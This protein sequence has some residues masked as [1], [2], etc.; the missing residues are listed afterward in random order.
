MKKT[1]IRKLNK[2]KFWF[3]KPKDVWYV[4][5]AITGLKNYVKKFAK[6][7]ARLRK[8]G[9]KV[10]NP[11]ELDNQIFSCCIFAVLWIFFK[12]IRVDTSWLPYI[13]RDIIIMYKKRVNRMNMLPNWKNSTG[14]K[15]EKIIAKE[16][17]GAKITYSKNYK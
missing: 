6:P 7:T 3:S 12:I 4:S 10:V 14:A 16:K 5:G 2:I 9:C 15:I 17:L 13:I 8:A 1:K 11:V